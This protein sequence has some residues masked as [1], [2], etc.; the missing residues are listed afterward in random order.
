MDTVKASSHGDQH[1]RCTTTRRPALVVGACRRPSGL[2]PSNSYDV[3]YL[4]VRISGPQRR[5]EL[6]AE[7]L[8]VA[9]SPS[10]P[11]RAAVGGGRWAE[12]PIALLVV[13]R[14]PAERLAAMA[15]AASL[16]SCRYFRP[17][18]DNKRAQRNLTLTA[19]EQRAT[20]SFAEITLVERPRDPERGIVP[21]HTRL[22]L[23]RPWCRRVVV[24]LG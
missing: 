24:G 3:R 22:R 10:S 16:R 23:R 14:K 11:D 8:C 19:G 13:V 18:Q 17:T 7:L 15:C 2:Q 6:Q 12:P 4:D 21:S 20:A 1:H 5:A 9:R